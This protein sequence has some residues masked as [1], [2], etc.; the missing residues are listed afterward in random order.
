MSDEVLSIKEVA[1]KL[2]G[3]VSSEYQWPAEVGQGFT[4]E[5]IWHHDGFLILD[6]LN[7]D[8]AM[9][10][11]EAANVYFKTPF[12]PDGEPITWVHLKKVGIPFMS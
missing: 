1:K 9:F 12:K 8:K 11:S 4:L 7:K 10:W 3:V 6:F 2:S 5:F